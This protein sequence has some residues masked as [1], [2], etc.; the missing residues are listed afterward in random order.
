MPTSSLYSQK[1]QDH[2][3]QEIV[4]RDAS[5]AFNGTTKLGEAVVILF[6]YACCW[7]LEIQ[8]HLLL[9]IWLHIH[10]DHKPLFPSK[11]LK[12]PPTIVRTKDIKKLKQTEQIPLVNIK[13]RAD[14]HPTSHGSQLLP[15]TY[16]ES[17]TKPKVAN[18]SEHI[19][20]PCSTWDRGI[21]QWPTECLRTL[22]Q[23]SRS[24]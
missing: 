17:P 10:M 15:S 8:F 22:G 2:I 6:K 14:Y 20:L 9:E 3:K 18:H 1:E 12:E 16:W 5:V 13:V 11:H 7:W 24:Y 19:C 23:V 4:G 21:T